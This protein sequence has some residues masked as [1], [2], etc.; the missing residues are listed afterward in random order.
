MAKVEDVA[1]YILEKSGPMSAIK[2]QKLVYYCQAW[3]L[4]W[5]EAP[6]FDSRIEAWANGPVC[7][8]LHALHKGEFMVEPNMNVGDSSRLSADNRDVVDNVLKGYGDKSAHW[9]V[10]LSHLEEPWKDA[11]GCALPGQKCDNEISHAAMAEYYS[12]L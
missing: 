6:L 3:A 4:V 2:L 12:G 9:L 10:E 5:T 7:P 8:D 11:R 1:Q